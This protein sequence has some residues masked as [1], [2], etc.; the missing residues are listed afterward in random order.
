MPARPHQP[1]ASSQAVLW[2]PPTPDGAPGALSLIPYANWE[3]PESQTLGQQIFAGEKK[4]KKSWFGS[5]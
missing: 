1:R 2:F 3:E 5:L 4:K